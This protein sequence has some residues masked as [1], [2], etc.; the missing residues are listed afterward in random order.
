MNKQDKRE[1]ILNHPHVAISETFNIN[2]SP[3]RIDKEVVQI[4]FDRLLSLIES[5]LDKARAIPE[6]H[7][8]SRRLKRLKRRRDWLESQS[9]S[10]P[11]R[12]DISH[13]RAELSAL[14]WAIEILEGLSPGELKQTNENNK[15]Y[16]NGFCEECGITFEQ[17]RGLDHDPRANKEGRI[18][19]CYKDK[20]FCASKVKKHTCGREFT[21]E[22]A[23]K[24]EEWWG[25]DNYP[26]AWAEFCTELNITKENTDASSK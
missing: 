12:T 24:A 11:D 10:T 18:I 19:I 7:K 13:T 1:R 9:S 16:A 20:S 3:A 17:H 22:D 26:V 14:N 8:Y 21:K 6:P 2:G 23:K 4:R 25:G 5:E 15:V